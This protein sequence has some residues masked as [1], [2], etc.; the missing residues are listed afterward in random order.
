MAFSL[1]SYGQ[2]FSDSMKIMGSLMGL[3]F[4]EAELKQ[5]A[6]SVKGWQEDYAQ[7]RKVK[8]ENSLRPALVFN[9]I[10]IGA[11]FET[12]QQPIQWKLEKVKLPSNK[13][14]IAFFSIG[15]LAWLIKNKKITSVELTQI[16]LNR[17]KKHGD[18]LQCV[19]TL[20]EEEAL[21]QAQE[22]DQELAEGKWR[23]PLHG[24]PY[25]I[26]DL[27]AVPGTKTTWGAMPYREQEI[28]QTATVVTKLE[29]AGGVLLA[30]LTLGALAMG[31]VWYGGTTKNPWDLNQGSSGSSAG[32]ASATVAGLVGFSIGTETLGS[33]VSPSTRC[34][35]SGLRPTFG[36]VSKYGAM[37]LSW[38]MDK[39]G[40][41]CRYAEDC[42]YVFA[43]I[44]GKDDKDP[45]SLQFA[46]NYEPRLK[47]KNLKVG[48]ASNLF[49]SSYF[50][51]KNDSTSLEA[52]RNAGI[53]LV[54]LEW[55]TEA[56]VGAI[57][58]VLYAEAAA[59][60]DELT[61]SNQDSLLVRQSNGAWPNIF[62]YSRFI[63]AVEYIQ[64]MRLRQGL[65]QE[66]HEIMQQVDVL[67]V[68]S[69]AG[70][71]LRATNLTGHPVVVV[72]NGRN[73]TGLA[74]ICFLGNLFDEAKILTLAKFYQDH[75][76]FDDKH[77]EMFSK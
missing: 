67:V 66:I 4:S 64:A 55:K 69:Y 74:S 2:S 36:R 22:R 60:F 27:L 57:G 56:P 48:Y 12:V 38:T 68:P 62:R 40:P 72:P 7:I 51:Y 18:T 42:A 59:A 8:I 13:D 28:N 46:F 1:L 44:H 41:I 50:N 53:E 76:G 24:I 58:L 65:V 26:K 45:S 37:A 52:L 25:G 73:S 21:Q 34:G 49:K 39:I 43:A 32:S 23:G 15:Q 63:P 16:Y 9:P 30:K 47:A 5:M 17:I 10:P 77:P 3:D 33:I 61:R 31:D 71:Q 29:E 35:A 54:P 75:T 11:Q 6:S 19:I 70:N 20:L 14:E